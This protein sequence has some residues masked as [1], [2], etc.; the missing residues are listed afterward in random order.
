MN[1]IYLIVPLIGMLIFGGFYVNFYNQYEAKKVLAAA[2][3]EEARKEKIKKEAAARDLAIQNAIAAQ[4]LRKQE[5]LA[6]EKI[7]EEK[8]LARQAAEDRREKAYNDK[9]RLTTQVRNLKKDLDDIQAEIVKIQTQ[10]KSLLDEQNFLKSYVK[11]AESNVKYYYE[12]LD[13]IALAER[14]RAA[15]AAVAAAAAKK[16]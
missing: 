12:L 2:K 9:N 13:K 8:K 4:E 7:E 15:A 6:K 10:N 14:E 11:Q 16:S 1:K 5:R 3:V